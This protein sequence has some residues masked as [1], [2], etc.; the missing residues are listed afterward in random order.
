ML[1][2][3]VARSPC[4]LRLV[5]GHFFASASSWTASS[6]GAVTLGRAGTFRRRAARSRRPTRTAPPQDSSD[7]RARSEGLG[8]ASRRHGELRLLGRDQRQHGWRRRGIAAADRRVGLERM[9][10]ERVHDAR[11]R[12]RL[13]PG[14]ARLVRVSVV[15]RRSI[16]AR[17]SRSSRWTRAARRAAR[18]TDGTVMAVLGRHQL[19]A[20][21]WR[22]W[23][24]FARRFGRLDGVHRRVRIAGGR[25]L[26]V[27]FVNLGDERARI[28]GISSPPAAPAQSRRPCR[29]VALTTASSRCRNALSGDAAMA[30]S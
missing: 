21:F 8:R 3:D 25:P 20:A 28:A 13:D 10:R 6:L 19:D 16:R 22:I 29:R 12:H 14:A 2:G 27:A 4:T 17:R 11:A 9:V 15:V 24:I 7:A 18:V 1:Y 30:L 26:L 23:S 5:R